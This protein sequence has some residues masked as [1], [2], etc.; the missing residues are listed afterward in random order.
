MTLANMLEKFNLDYLLPEAHETID[1]PTGAAIG[2]MP[3]GSFITDQLGCYEAIK[4]VAQDGEL[5]DSHS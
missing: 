2:L 1:A 3:N 5:E 4:A